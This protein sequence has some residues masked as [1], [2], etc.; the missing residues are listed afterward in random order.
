MD[1]VAEGCRDKCRYIF[2]ALIG[3]ERIDRNETVFISKDGRRIAVEGRCQTT[4]ENGKAVAMTGIF[5]DISE[6]VKNDLALRESEQRFRTLFENSTDIMQI[7]ATNGH[8]LH[9]NPAWLKAFGYNRDEVSNLTIF[10]LIAPDCQGHCKKT[11]QQVLAEDKVHQIDTTFIA[12]DGQRI[13]IEGSATAIFKD[14]NP[15]YSQCIFRDVT[16]KR[17]MEEE[18]LKTQKLESIGVFAGGLA[19]DFN[20]LLI[21]VL[22]NISLAKAT[23][24]ENTPLAGQL[25]KAEKAALRAKGLT[26]Q[27]LTFAKGGAPIKK[28]SG[29]ADLVRDSVDFSLRGSNVKQKYQFAPDLWT[30]EVDEDQLSQVIQNLVINAGQ[31]MPDGGS[32]TVTGENITLGSDNHTGLPAGRYLLLTVSDEGHGISRQDQDKIFDPYF[33]RKERGSGLGLAVAYAIM[34]KHDGLITVDSAP[35]TGTTFS[36]YLPAARPRFEKAGKQQYEESTTGGH[37]LIMD[38]ERIV[39]DVAAEMLDFLGYTNSSAEH[40][41][42][43]I[44]LYRAAMS[45]GKPFDAVLMDL[46]IP[47]GMGGQETMARLL[48]IDPQATGIVSSGYANDPI[49]ANFTDYGFSAVIPKPYEMDE[50]RTTLAQ[51]LPRNR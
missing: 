34:K 29:I 25:K 39:R 14:G 21:A 41:E 30:A 23:A 11:F 16:E 22:G 28:L 26:H 42:Q 20:N 32:L 12:K 27:L 51:A 5:R 13:E 24:A 1:I 47:G 19:H 18:I 44:T 45:N 3:G 10:D 38:D 49:M 2:K 48:E 15:L 6:Q 17:K 37:I 43:A 40:G 46:T 35:G 31:A 36:L 8:F 33:S 4:F 50:L 9:V 7:V